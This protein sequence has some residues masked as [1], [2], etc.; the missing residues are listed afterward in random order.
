VR[1]C[2]PIL[3]PCS[4]R[5]RSSIDCPSSRP[6]IGARIDTRRVRPPL[7]ARSDHDVEPYSDEWVMDVVLDGVVRMVE[8]HK[9]DEFMAELDAAAEA[10]ETALAL[11]KTAPPPPLATAAAGAAAPTDAE[12]CESMR[13]IKLQHRG[14]TV[15]QVHARLCAEKHPGP[16]DGV[17]LSR[18]K[19]LAPV[20]YRDL[21]DARTDS[22]DGGGGARKRRASLRG[23]G[24]ELL[25]GLEPHRAALARAGRDMGDP[26]VLNQHT[27]EHATRACE[28]ALAGDFAGAGRIKCHFDVPGVDPTEQQLADAADYFRGRER[29]DLLTEIFRL[30]K[31]A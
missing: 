18:T 9:V 11:A 19:K 29:D 13:R 30:R 31:I 22:A 24:A 23:T 16:C 28:L 3:A 1:A 6:P 2:S 12:L 7:S 4:S 5:V 20:A 17:T 21:E 10:A 15:Q 27:A 26:V 14:D 8:W 25:E